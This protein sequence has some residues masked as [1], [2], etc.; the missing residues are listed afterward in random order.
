MP[1]TEERVEEERSEAKSFRDGPGQLFGLER[2]K[3]VLAQLAGMPAQ[4]ACDAILAALLA[5]QSGA[6]QEDDITLVAIRS[7][8]QGG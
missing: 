8:A 2:L 4:H 6:A 1:D 3:P 5:Y 7:E